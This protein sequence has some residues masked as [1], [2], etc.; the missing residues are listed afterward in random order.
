MARLSDRCG[1][2]IIFVWHLGEASLR[3]CP[4]DLNPT[5]ARL[6]RSTE[7]SAVYGAEFVADLSIC[8]EGD[9]FLRRRPVFRGLAGRAFGRL[10][11]GG[12]VFRSQQRIGVHR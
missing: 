4:V 1:C 7:P 5:T 10:M 2:S 12:S 9:W 11:P 3:G 8:P 6:Q